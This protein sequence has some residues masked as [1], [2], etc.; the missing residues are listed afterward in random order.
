MKFL[1]ASRIAPDETP[2]FAASHLGLFCLLMSHKKDVRLLW[3]KV[4]ILSR[5]VCVFSFEHKSRN[6]YR[7][8]HLRQLHHIMMDLFHNCLNSKLQSIGTT[9]EM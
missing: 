8:H 3:I 7:M 6:N 4:Q 1:L 5:V 9:H 2:H